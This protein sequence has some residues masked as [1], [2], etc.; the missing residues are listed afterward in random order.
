MPREL[1]ISVNLIAYSELKDKDIILGSGC[2]TFFDQKGAMNPNIS[3]IYIWPLFKASSRV[4]MGD[5]YHGSY[6]NS[7]NNNEEN[8]HKLMLDKSDFCIVYLEFQKFAKPLIHSLK[9]LRE[10]KQFLRIKYPYVDDKQNTFKEIENLYSNSLDNLD[11][12]LNSLKDK[13]KYFSDLNEMKLKIDKI[14][15]EKIDGSIKKEN[16]KSENEKDKKTWLKGNPFENKKDDNS[17]DQAL[18]SK[19]DEDADR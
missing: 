19:E 16:K 6:S 11:I 17:D 5:A 13:D 8:P 12:I 4:V 9:T 1:R 2:C 3:E 14:D 15:K 10:E 18:L 7:S